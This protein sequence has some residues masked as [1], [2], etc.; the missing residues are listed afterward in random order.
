[1][2]ISKATGASLRCSGPVVEPLGAPS[3]SA[4]LPQ[5]IAAGFSA[6]AK[7]V[8]GTNFTANATIRMKAFFVLVFMALFALPAFAA[9]PVCMYQDVQSG[10]ATGGQGGNGIYLDIYGLNFG[11][12][13]GSSTVTVNGTPVAQYIYWGADPTG[14][15]QQIGV[16]IASGTTG[17]GNI[18][19]TTPGGS[20][21]NL[22]FTVRSGHIWFIGPAVD[23]ST[24]ASCATMEAANSYSTPWGLD[25]TDGPNVTDGTP[26]YSTYR[27]P[28]TYLNCLPPGDVLV[29][30]NGTTWPYYDS[31][32]WHASLTIP[33]NETCSASS[34]YTVMARPGAT[35]LFGSLTN[36]TGA[37]T[38][39]SYKGLVDLCGNSVIAGLGVT[40]ATGGG[41]SAS[42][43]GSSTLWSRFIGNEVQCPTCD[44]SDGALDSGN[45]TNAYAEILGNWVTN[46]GT[47]AN[48]GAGTGKTFHN[49]YI[50]GSNFEFAWNR[51]S[52]S[53]GAGY[54]YNGVQV[55]HDGGSGYFNFSIHDNDISDVNGSGINL[56][57]I[58]PSSGYVQTYNNIIH[59]T[60]LALGSDGG[61]DDPHSCIAVKGYGGA[62]EAGTAYIWNNTM[63][64]CSSFLNNSLAVSGQG[65][66]CTIFIPA[67]QLNVTTN[68][69]NNVVYQPAYTYSGNYN[70]YICGD[71][72]AGTI[73]GSNNIWY[74]ASTP[75]STAYA[76]AVGTIENPL[77]VNSIDGAWTN[78]ELQ[79]GSPAVGE[80]LRV[81]PIE[82]SGV[83]NTY[84]TWDFAQATRPNPPSIGALEY[85]STSSVEQITVSATP[86]PAILGQ[87]VTLTATVGQT[88]SSVPTGSINFLNGSVSL[89]QASL[90]S[91]GTATL[92]LSSLS[93]GSY[94]VVG[95]Y[96]GDSHYPAG[97]SSVVSLQVLSATATTLV[98]SPNPVT[99]GQALDLTATVS[100][101]TSPTGTVSFMNGSTVLGTATLN[102][103]GV[104]TLSTTSL[105]VGTYSLAAQYTGTA[106][107]PASTSAAASVTVNA[108]T[109]PIVPSF[110]M[111]VSGSTPSSVLPGETAVYSLV[112]TPTVGTTLPAITFAASGLPA[113]ATA[114][115]SPQEIAAGGGT[116]NVTMS[117][118]TPAA[119]SAR[120]ER[121]RE[122]G[123][124]LPIVALGLL[125]LPFG[126]GSRRFGKR[127]MRLSCIV[128]LL[129]GAA[130]LAGLTG[131]GA[132][133]SSPGA[134]AQ[135]YTFTVTSASASTSVSQ[136]A[137]VTLA[138]E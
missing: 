16:Q 75:G 64:D 17:T 104:A 105:A 132:D 98:A 124:G 129:A 4:V 11:T 63:Y 84:L 136:T 73:S 68:L 101:T 67:N 22:T 79:S 126:R 100:G 58:D 127:M 3:I 18:V 33:N 87:P 134:N 77:Y 86:N 89:G 25:T 80:G 102:S 26:V 42:T 45:Y 39:L 135:T 107:F 93:A 74:S 76:T 117:I 12:S 14:D 118:Q 48:S 47:T 94:A 13:Q 115:F 10:P 90:N 60:G 5:T 56:S 6:V 28:Y 121:N 51:I 114:T 99:A 29:F 38:G 2:K 20:C 62:T 49:V 131:C 27:T 71:G 32:G 133:V 41:N 19:V 138:A 30:L 119:Q 120:L 69:V 53:G 70:V 7:K 66:S 8:T 97:E 110:S 50:S 103:S 43:G 36:T 44:G 81:G 40:G 130:S 109:A 108:A 9:T 35:T 128:L 85:G 116:T 111:T 95:S 78:Y 65:E 96:S 88:A 61:S 54:A 46:V 72:T 31:R 24:P 21:S 112:V 55:H 106:S 92:V 91:E 34:F 23:T 52:N 83:S 1:L 123:G 125:L 57:V 59:H 37:L 82:S 15:R 122:L 113:G 137:Q